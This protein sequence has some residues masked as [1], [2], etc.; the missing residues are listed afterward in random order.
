MD[1]RCYSPI[2]LVSLH[3][4][5]PHLL[6]VK[7]VA[8]TVK[9]RQPPNP[10]LVLDNTVLISPIASIDTDT[11]DTSWLLP[12]ELVLLEEVFLFSVYVMSCLSSVWGEFGVT[13]ACSFHLPCGSDLGWFRLV[14]YYHS[15]SSF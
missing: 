2:S 13:G 4:S 10:A 14:A 5:T 11:A 1:V 6:A 7:I 9:S 3:K 12:E 8:A 15:C